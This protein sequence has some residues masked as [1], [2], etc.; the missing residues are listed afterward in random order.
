MVRLKMTDSSDKIGPGQ[1]KWRT[2]I[3]RRLK[4]FTSISIQRLD[5]NAKYK[6][7]KELPNKLSQSVSEKKYPQNP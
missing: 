2:K 3:R 5:N 7:Q 1:T 6:A 4:H